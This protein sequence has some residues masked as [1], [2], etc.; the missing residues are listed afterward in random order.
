MTVWTNSVTGHRAGDLTPK[1][2]RVLDFIVAFHDRHN[3]FPSWRQMRVEFAYRSRGAALYH[4][5]K[6]EKK[7]WLAIRRMRFLA[8]GGRVTHS[9][10]IESAVRRTNDTGSES[11]GYLAHT[12]MPLATQIEA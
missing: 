10:R 9:S 2:A 6:L 11:E 12:R 5:D 8:P 1:E 7:G 4:V 3:R